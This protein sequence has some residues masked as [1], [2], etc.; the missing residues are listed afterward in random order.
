[1]NEIENED[2]DAQ[3]LPMQQENDDMEFKKIKTGPVEQW[4]ASKLRQKS[5]KSSSYA[6]TKDAQNV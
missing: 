4:T 2:F 5:D 1:M 6:T 3:S